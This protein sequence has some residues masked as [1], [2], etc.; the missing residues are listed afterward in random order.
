MPRLT[1]FPGRKPTPADREELLRIWGTLSDD[2]RKVTTRIRTG[3]SCLHSPLASP[4]S[5]EAQFSHRLDRVELSD[6]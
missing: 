2:G 5:L 1:H 6:L 3:R 4:R